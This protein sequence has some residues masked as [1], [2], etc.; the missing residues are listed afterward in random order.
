MAD[1]WLALFDVTGEASLHLGLL[2]LAGE[3][4]DPGE[5]IWEVLLLVLMGLDPSLERL[6]RESAL[7]WLEVVTLN[8]LKT[9]EL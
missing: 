3:N 9:L 2:C 5:L 8:Q 6:P 4:T 1:D 7:Y